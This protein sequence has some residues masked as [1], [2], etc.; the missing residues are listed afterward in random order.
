MITR[1]IDTIINALLLKTTRYWVAGIG[2]SA[3]YRTSH[4]FNRYNSLFEISARTFYEH[5]GC[6]EKDIIL[7]L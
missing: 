3:N 5:F 1:N 2:R 6:Q 4:D 7:R